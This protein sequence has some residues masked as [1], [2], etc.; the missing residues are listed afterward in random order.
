MK[1]LFVIIAIILAALI[2][3]VDHHVDVNKHASS[4]CRD[5]ELS[6]VD[7]LAHFE[8]DSILQARGLASTPE[9]SSCRDSYYRGL[10]SDAGMALMSCGNAL[11]NAQI[12]VERSKLIKAEGKE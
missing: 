11:R 12:Q 10:L 7:S 5:Y 4:P 2:V 6:R 9:P 3:V 8:L 1:K